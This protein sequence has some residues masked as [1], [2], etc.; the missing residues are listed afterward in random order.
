MGEEETTL[1]HGSD[2]EKPELG[3]ILRCSYRLSPEEQKP[4]SSVWGFATLGYVPH[5]LR[6]LHLLK[7]NQLAADA[8][9]G[10]F[11]TASG[12]EIASV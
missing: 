2:P 6:L 7:V 4:G 8:S 5:A 12:P 10:R 9:V 1:Y 11:G 3:S